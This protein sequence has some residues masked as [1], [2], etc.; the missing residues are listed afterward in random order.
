M[1]IQMKIWI[2]NDD[3]LPLLGEGR[4]HIL[5]A[6]KKTGSIS[7]AAREL[8]MSYRAAWGKVRTTEKRLGKILVKGKSG[9]ASHGGA[10]LTEDALDLIDYFESFLKE[11]DKTVNA[12][13][14]DMLLN[15]F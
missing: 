3:G 4:I 7:G 8:G 9:G 12:L 14:K 1:K 2:E 6:I 15:R 5:K 10:A 13:A 11:A